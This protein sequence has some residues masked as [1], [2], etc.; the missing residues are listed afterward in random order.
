MKIKLDENIP[1]EQPH[2]RRAVLQNFVVESL[3]REACAF[4]FF[5]ILTQLQRF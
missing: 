4:L 5:P 2:R 3:G 1:G